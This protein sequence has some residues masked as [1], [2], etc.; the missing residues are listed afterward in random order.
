MESARRGLKSVKRFSRTAGVAAALAV[1]ASLLAAPQA[2]AEDTPSSRQLMEAC[3]WADLCEFHPQSYSTY[4]GPRHQVGS[5]AFNCGSLPNP[6]QIS[7]ADTTGAT[8]SLGMSIQV[9]AK[10][11]EV[12]EVSVE[13]TYRHDWTVSHTDTESNSVNIPPGSKGWVERATAMQQATGWYELHFP[14]RYYGHYIW[15]VHDYQS[16]GYTGDQADLQ[17]TY[18]RDTPMTEAERAEHC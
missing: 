5:T 1:G 17:H 4:T 6:H 9:G 2:S 12:Y 10:F 15:Y 8:N 18:L 3:S 13:A 14:S 16:S 7:W 11:W